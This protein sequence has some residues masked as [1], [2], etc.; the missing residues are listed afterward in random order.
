M[1]PM[2][3]PGIFAYGD[4]IGNELVDIVV[5][6]DGDNRIFIL[7]QTTAGQFTRILAQ[8][9]GIPKKSANAYSMPLPG[10]L[11][12]CSS[13]FV[14]TLTPVQKPPFT[15]YWH[16]LEHFRFDFSGIIQANSFISK[17]HIPFF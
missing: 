15:L 13:T 10:V 14:S 16:G 17:L 1:S 11:V 2:W 7:E 5:S 9:M 6:V 12:F 3:A 8:E 4:V